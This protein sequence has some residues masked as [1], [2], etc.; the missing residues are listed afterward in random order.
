MKWLGQKL[1]ESEGIKESI[2]AGLPEKTTAAT[3]T[4]E[5]PVEQRPAYLQQDNELLEEDMY[6]DYNDV[7]AG[8]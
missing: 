3:G 2:K 6:A 4:T 8:V 7:C 1:K 5:L